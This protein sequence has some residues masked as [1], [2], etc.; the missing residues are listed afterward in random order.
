MTPWLG[1]LCDGASHTFEVRVA[2]MDDNRN[3]KP[4]VGGFWLVTGTVFVFLDKAGSVTKGS[5]PQRYDPGPRV[6]APHSTVT[7]GP[8]GSNQELI[9]STK[10]QRNFAVVNQI[11]TSS[12][13]REV[14]WIQNLTYSN[15][16][17]ISQ[18]GFYTYTT[19]NISGTDKTADYS[20]NYSFPLS[21]NFSYTVFP[22]GK[23]KTIQGNLS[24]GLDLQIIGQAVFPSGLNS[25]NLSSASAFTPAD[26]GLLLTIPA[27]GALYSNTSSTSFIGS[28]LS[29]ALNSSTHY[30][31]DGCTSKGV[32]YGFTEQSFSFGGLTRSAPSSPKELYSRHVKAINGTLVT[33]DQTFAGQNLPVPHRQLLEATD[34]PMS[35]DMQNLGDVTPHQFLGRTGP[36][37]GDDAA[38]AAEGLHLPLSGTGLQLPNTTD[39][40]RAGPKLAIR[41]EDCLA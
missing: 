26:P 16:N 40:S 24:Q 8:D 29:T 2:G 18:G 5:Y 39:P 12:G 31:L 1:L 32:G 37:G 6:D 11:T 25:F 9:Y 15:F 41:G 30:T 4:T 7:K 14:S 23:P 21:S 13:S 17:H 19:Q 36:S 27:K 35:F 10:L 3:L 28:S 33:D 38:A 20:T 34:P 22:D